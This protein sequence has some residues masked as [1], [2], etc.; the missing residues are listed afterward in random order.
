MPPGDDTGLVAARHQRMRLASVTTR[1]PDVA[2]LWPR[3]PNPRFVAAAPETLE[4]AEQM[5]M[6]KW[7]DKDT[8]AERERLHRLQV[9]VRRCARTVRRVRNACGAAFR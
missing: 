4:E 5:F 3:A 7:Q 1:R 8:P 2:L 6:G 9:Q